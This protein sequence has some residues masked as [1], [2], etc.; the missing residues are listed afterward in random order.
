ME[1]IIMI[2]QILKN[3]NTNATR[4]KI[5]GIIKK[6]I[7][8]RLFKIKYILYWILYYEKKHVT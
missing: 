6:L 2:F 7:V 1:Y 3:K 5:R 4:N 8:P